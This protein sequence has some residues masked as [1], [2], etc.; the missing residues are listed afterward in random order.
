MQRIYICLSAA[1]LICLGSIV[2]AYA[3]STL[4][5][6][7]AKAI[8]EQETGEYVQNTSCGSV[9]AQEEGRKRQQAKN[10]TYVLR[11]LIL[12]ELPNM[13]AELVANLMILQKM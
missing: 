8:V 4:R 13:L 11:L 12:K 1:F 3:V 2:R 5:Y 7:F 9:R 10:A 6:F